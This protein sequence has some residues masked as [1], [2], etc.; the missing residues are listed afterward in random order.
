MKCRV[1]SIFV[2]LGSALLLAGMG[3]APASGATRL[4]ASSTPP[5]YCLEDTAYFQQGISGLF[6]Y[7]ASS[8]GVITSWL[9][10][11]PLEAGHTLQLL[12][13]RRDFPP[14]GLNHY[15]TVSRKDVVRPLSTVGENFFRGLSIPIEAGEE[16]GLYVPAG[17]P[18]VT[19]MGVTAPAGTCLFTAGGVANHY[20][21]RT[22]DPPTGIPVDFTSSGTGYRLNALAIVEPDADRDGFGDDTQDFCDT[23]PSTQGLCPV[24]PRVSA[25]A[26]TPPRV[27]GK[28]CKRGKHYKKVKGKLR[29]VRK[30]DRRKK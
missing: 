12:V 18:E 3:A 22:G 15:F 25:S 4:G 5:V 17:Q 11:T 20:R 16:I 14:G 23:D 29:C 26:T 8:Y 10:G 7:T 28:K 9:T 21:Y 27:P 6:G 24:A 13:A 19:F 1:R 30:K 2:A